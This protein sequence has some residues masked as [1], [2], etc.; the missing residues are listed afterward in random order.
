MRY[1][2][3]LYGIAC[4]LLF[5]ASFLGAIA[6]VGD[7]VPAIPVSV[8]RGP[9]APLGI[10]LLIDAVL[11]TLFAVQHSVITRPGDL[12]PLPARSAPHHARLP[13]RGHCLATL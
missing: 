2:A 11:L 13:R 5:L 6:F 12:R 10:A 1:I 7:L 4:Y 8:D 3:F 9:E